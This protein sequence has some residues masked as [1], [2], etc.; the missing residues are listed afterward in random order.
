MH[1]LLIYICFKDGN[2]KRPKNSPEG[3]V[4]RE[5]ESIPTPQGLMLQ[6]I[7]RVSRDKES[8]LLTENISIPLEAS[9]TEFLIQA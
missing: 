5:V 3:V 7:A 6:N 8:S 1:G 4:Y 2:K 9:I